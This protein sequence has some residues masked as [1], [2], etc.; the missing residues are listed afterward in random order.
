MYIFTYWDVDTVSP[1]INQCISTWRSAFPGANIVVLD[2]RSA[3]DLFAEVRCLWSQ[4]QRLPA[5]R[6]S[7]LCRVL[8]VFQFG[9]L[10]L[11]AS[12]VVLPEMR[13]QLLRA[14][15]SLM[16]CP[17][18]GAPELYENYCIYA[19]SPRHPVLDSWIRELVDL[20][21]IGETVYARQGIV[22][23]SLAPDLPYLSA[24]LALARA[25][26]ATSARVVPLQGSLC[27]LSHAMLPA[28]PI[29]PV[30]FAAVTMLAVSRL[31]LAPTSCN[32]AL[33]KLR[34]VDRRWIER[35]QRLGFFRRDAV[36]PVMLN[37]DYAD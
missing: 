21:R 15:K 2:D 3:Y 35:F 28:R 11:D 33:I 19:E 20:V 10:W 4:Y 27:H 18:Q 12:T 26:S 25:M 5:Y 24:H 16:L 13:R 8:S 14:K 1:L 36:L 34:G 17:M 7:D 29:N 22:P 6:R 37:W 31:L 32:S 23:A 30:S 9:G